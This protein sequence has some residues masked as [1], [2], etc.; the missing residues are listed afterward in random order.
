M[1]QRMC[2]EPNVDT[3]VCVKKKELQALIW[4]CVGRL[5]QMWLPRQQGRREILGGG[6]FLPL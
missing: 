2:D 6:G 1:A 4:L 5:W 3:W